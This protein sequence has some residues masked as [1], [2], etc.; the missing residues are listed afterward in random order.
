MDPIS[1]T[2]T[3]I[4]LAT[5][6]KDLV[7][8]GQSIK[9][10]IEK[11]GENRRRIRDLTDETL[12]SLAELASLSRGHEEIYQTPALLSALGDLK[13]DMLHVLS[14][15]RKKSPVERRSG[16]RGFGS[17]LKVWI[18]REEIEKEIRN[19]KEHVDRCY[20]KFTAF[21]AA[22]IEQ[23]TAR[24]EST[25][26]GTANTALRV[27]QTVLMSQVENRV[28]LRR[29][30][31]MMA[32]VLLQ[33]QFGQ[34]YMD[35]TIEIISS[36]PT[37]HSL[38]FQ[39]LSA[40]TMRLIQSLQNLMS[41]G[42]LVL[43]SDHSVAEFW[44]CMKSPMALAHSASPSHVLHWILGVVLE[45]H[46]S[47]SGPQMQ[48][49]Q[50]IMSGL[51]AQLVL[52]GMASEAVAWEAFVIQIFGHVAASDC[53]ADDRFLSQ[54]AKSQR[55]L[56][57][58]YQYQLRFELA[59]QA[60]TQALDILRS[61]SPAETDT[62]V[63]PLSTAIL[64]T[65]SNNLCET[66]QHQTAIT[67]AREAVATCRPMVEQIIQQG[68]DIFSYS[69]EAEY[70][71]VVSSQAFFTLAR[72]LSC[73]DCHV[74]AYEISKEGFQIVLASSQLIRRPPAG[75][76]VD[77]FIDLLCK[78]AE[79]DAL[80]LSLL[81]DSVILFRDLARIYP[82]AF[83]SQFL[84]L[85]CAYG[86]LSE[87]K[88]FSDFSMVLKKLR[89]F[90]E[91]GW[92]SPPPV[93]DSSSNL[94]MHLNDFDPHGGAFEDVIR[95]SYFRPWDG[96]YLFVPFIRHLFVTHFDQA[97][98]VLRDL[99]MDTTSNSN[100]LL[101][102]ALDDI[103]EFILPVVPLAEQLV[104]IEIIEGMVSYFRVVSI[105]TSS[106]NEGYSL[107]EGLFHSLQGFWLVGLLDKALGAINEFIEHVRSCFDA[108]H[109]DH[110]NQLTTLQLRRTFILY[111]TRA[112]RGAKR[113][114]TSYYDYT[115]QL[116]LPHP[117]RRRPK[118]PSIRVARR[119]TPDAQIGIGPTRRERLVCAVQMGTD[120]VI[121]LSCRNSPRGI[122]VSTEG[123]GSKAGRGYS[124][125]RV[126]NAQDDLANVAS[127]L[128]KVGHREESIAACG[129][130]VNII[131]KL[132]DTETYFLPVLV[133][134]L[135]QLAGYLSEKG[136]T[137]RASAEI[138]EIDKIKA[139]I[140]SMPPEPEFLF[141]EIEMEPE[142]ELW[143]PEDILEGTT[144]LVLAER[145]RSAHAVEPKPTHRTTPLPGTHAI[146]TR[147][148]K[149]LLAACLTAPAATYFMVD[150]SHH[151]RISMLSG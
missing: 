27:E 83:L 32:R 134:G 131:R 76:Y 91:P 104:L 112:R 73:A 115:F 69:E 4:T 18:K 38:E 77:L 47:E 33:D 68:S 13:A 118:C 34:D 35:Q 97:V 17:Q 70:K 135:D 130:A 64:V 19:L 120:G 7:E 85:I 9:S 48:S 105:S 20:L 30:E 111:D 29:L 24:M 125:Y 145:D 55:K 45:I 80:S 52:M 144:F 79:N 26:L 14:M 109:E 49:L 127:L 143:E 89:I 31:G 46:D 40:Q 63:Q 147:P 60:S 8:V 53:P 126:P 57:I 11:V 149:S 10:S 22:R 133:E 71:A 25:S 36:D 151:F 75:T 132:A 113:P 54:L 96:S 12:R 42:Y 107:A 146:Q 90:L 84:R 142:H 67:I 110:A 140:V 51:G 82:E 108:D 93:L 21:S 98:A 150:F 103:S 23:R 102:R 95:A 122:R 114:G 41:A 43:S 139:K 16:L 3:V 39:Y 124:P 136:D 61:L 123:L 44:D 129:E 86:Y 100:P 2:T 128:W 81:S 99:V 87:R 88:N 117:P 28:Q 121:I 116:R 62:E 50:N 65:H 101:S 15:C 78:L 1:V 5:F 94:E 58:Y 66:G 138:S 59:L 37:H 92:D 6:I 119:P 74:E 72:A 56:S 106:Q 148:T 141:G 137:E